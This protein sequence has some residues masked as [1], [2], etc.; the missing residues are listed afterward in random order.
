LLSIFPYICSGLYENLL[1]C[2]F[3]S[4]KFLY[5]LGILNSL[6]VSF[7]SNF[8]ENL[9]SK[10]GNFFALDLFYLLINFNSSMDLFDLFY[11][12]QYDVPTFYDFFSV[13]KG[14]VRRFQDR[15]YGT[16]SW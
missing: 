1:Q 10:T 6:T 15:V 13:I 2:T 5:C 4:F 14:T 12:L 7:S 16:V 8:L 11:L 9:L 3:S